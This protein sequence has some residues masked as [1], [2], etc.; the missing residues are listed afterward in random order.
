V[1]LVDRNWPP[2]EDWIFGSAYGIGAITQESDVG[3]LLSKVN[4]GIGIQSN[5]EHQLAAATY[6][7]SMVDCATLD[8]LWD[9]Q[10]TNE[11]PKNVKYPK[12]ISYLHD[13]Q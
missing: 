7:A 9:D 10:E 6:S 11:E 4:C 2:I 12:S 5:W 8:C 1:F 13:N 3:A